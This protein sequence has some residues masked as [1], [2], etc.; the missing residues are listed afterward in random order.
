MKSACLSAIKGER[1]KRLGVG[2]S[3]GRKERNKAYWFRLS[4]ATVFSEQRGRRLGDFFGLSCQERECRENQGV[5]FIFSLRASVCGLSKGPRLCSYLVKE[6][7][8]MFH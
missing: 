3:V 2:R 5:F 8:A 4:L 1:A 7:D 6:I